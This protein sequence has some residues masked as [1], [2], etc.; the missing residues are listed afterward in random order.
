MAVG[1]S[2]NR[3][4]PFARQSSWSVRPADAVLSSFD[5]DRQIAVL[6]D[7]VRVG[8]HEDLVELGIQQ[9]SQ[10]LGDR[11]STFGVLASEDFVENRKARL[12]AAL[13]SGHPR[14]AETDA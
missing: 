9:R 8:D 12:D 11:A 13:A 14:Q 4:L 6:Q 5:V 7:I 1:A 2:A 3:L 10:L